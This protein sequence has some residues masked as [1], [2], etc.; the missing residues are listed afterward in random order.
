MFANA[1]LSRQLA[2][3]STLG[4]NELEVMSFSIELK[5]GQVMLGHEP[6]KGDEPALGKKYGDG[7]FENAKKA[8]DEALS[9]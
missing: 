9:N 8:V 2:R 1:V 3:T 5:D 6:K 7:R 4:I